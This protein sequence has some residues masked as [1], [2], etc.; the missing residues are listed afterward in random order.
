LPSLACKSAE[1]GLAP[2]A[3]PLAKVCTTERL[4]L[5][6]GNLKTLPKVEMVPP[7]VV[8][9]KLPSVA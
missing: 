7:Y 2:S 9:Y 8:P 5:A 6:K 3:A 4:L 1:E